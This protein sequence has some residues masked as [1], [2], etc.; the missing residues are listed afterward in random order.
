[1][2]L[3]H[4]TAVVLLGVASLSLGAKVD[5]VG[6]SDGAF[7]N[8]S[9]G[10]VVLSAERQ[11][12]LLHL[13]KH[14]CGAC[15]GMHMTGGLG[16]PLRPSTLSAKPETALVDAVLGGRPGTPMPPWRGLLTGDE[17]RWLVRYLRGEKP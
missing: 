16:P 2:M 9:V 13:L 8:R 14:D 15:H 1:M 4:G 5:A 11:A 12:E 3:L 6:G 10:Y 17:A 7:D